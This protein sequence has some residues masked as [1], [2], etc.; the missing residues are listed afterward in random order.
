MPT[1]G[2]R[3]DRGYG[4]E[5]EAERARW[6]PVVAR[7][8]ATCHAAHCVMPSRSIAPGE[9]WDLGHTSDRSTWTGPEHRRCNRRDGAVRG[10]RAR[11]GRGRGRWAL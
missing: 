7:G 2:T 5:H 10:N 4:P 9:P 6:A 3:Q 1:S 8:E 11:G